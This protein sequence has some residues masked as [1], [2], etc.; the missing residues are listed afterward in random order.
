M[1]VFIN[2]PDFNIKPSD[3][4]ATNITYS[5]P[6]KPNV[7]NVAQALQDM[8]EGK[9]DKIPGKG[10]STNDYTD[11]DKHKVDTLAGQLYFSSYMEFPPIGQEGIL[12]I[13]TDKNTSYLWNS[14][15]MVYVSMTIDD[16]DTA[17][18]I[19]GIL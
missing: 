2:V 1:A 14:V 9:V 18:T 17:Y 16:V 3:L 7:E 8:Y 4:T 15:E 5:N 11:E 19:Q 12:Y 10:L 13:A 6:E